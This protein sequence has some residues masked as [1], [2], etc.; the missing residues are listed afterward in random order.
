[1]LRNF[2]CYGIVTVFRHVLGYVTSQTVFPPMVKTNCGSGGVKGL[3]GVQV[4]FFTD[5]LLARASTSLASSQGELP[6][7]FDPFAWGYI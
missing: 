1:M 4:L 5:F 3:K 6:N 2:Q 7:W